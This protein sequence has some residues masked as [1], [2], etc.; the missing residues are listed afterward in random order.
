MEKPKRNRIPTVSINLTEKELRM[1]YRW[2][3]EADE[4]L[5]QLCN[6]GALTPLELSENNRLFDKLRNARFKFYHNA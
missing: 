6:D 1:I 5:H 4:Q 3:A 2:F